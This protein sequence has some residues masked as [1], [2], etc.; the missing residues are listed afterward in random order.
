MEDVDGRDKPGHD[1]EERPARFGWTRA[2][3]AGLAFRSIT[4]ADLPFLA[5]VYASTRWEELSVVAWS[6]AEKLAFLQQQ[7]DAQH[8]HWQRH[9]HDTDWLLVLHHG[10]P[11][12]RL[13]LSRWPR[14]HRI[15]DIALLPEHR[16]QGLGAALLQDLLA[17][18]L[19]K[20]EVGKELFEVA[21]RQSEQQ[22]VA[23]PI[24]GDVHS[25]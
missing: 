1:E 25:L 2:A 13:Y 22:P 14:E 16:G 24:R 11:V 19:D 23:G 10:E 3:A 21:R 12:G 5:R 8:A 17:V 20:L 9:Y 7:F 6:D 18:A 4:D 15:V